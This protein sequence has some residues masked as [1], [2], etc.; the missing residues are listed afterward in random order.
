MAVGPP[1]PA[2]ILRRDGETGASF[3]EYLAGLLVIAVVVGVVVA[4]GVGSTVLTNVKAAVCTVTGDDCAAEGGGGSDPADTG[5]PASAPSEEEWGGRSTDPFEEPPAPTEEETEAGQDAAEKIRDYLGNDDAWYKPWTWG[6][7][8]PEHPRDVLA[9]MSP[10]EIDALFDELSDDEIR[11]LLGVDGVPEILRLRADPYLLQQL[12][13]IAPDT[14]EPDFNDVRENGEKPSDPASDYGYIPNG[15]LFG[16]SGEPS[17]S[18]VNQGAIGDCWWLASMGA[19]AQTEEGRN[20]IR[21]MIRQNPNGTYTVSFPDGEQVTVTPSFP[22]K[23]AGNTAYAQAAGDPPVVWPLVLEKALAEREGSYGPLVGG[24]AS[25]GMETLT[26]QESTT[27]DTGD[28]TQEELQGWL[29]EGGVT[30]SSLT[31]DDADGKEAYEDGRFIAGH[32]YV[33]QDIGDDGKVRLYNPWGNT[34]ATVTMEE[35]NRYFRGV[36]TNP[37]R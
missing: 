27:Y 12:E 35:F 3:V 20:Q 15:Q 29:D 6:G 23:E 16:T 13:D 21:N 17:L 25:E 10:G 22:I 24:R 19:L 31:E 8:D 1:S 26:G 37:I 36:D 33:V 7:G 18:D 9:G 30:A 28:I 4:S 34:H 14:I 2:R 5:R 11:D 32:A